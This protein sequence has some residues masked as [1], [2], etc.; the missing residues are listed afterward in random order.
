MHPGK[1]EIPKYLLKVTDIFLTVH[2][3]LDPNKANTLSLPNVFMSSM[4]FILCSWHLFG[5]EIPR[6]TWGDAALWGAVSVCFCSLCSLEVSSWTLGIRLDLIGCRLLQKKNTAFEQ[7]FL[8]SEVAFIIQDTRDSLCV[9]L[10]Q[11]TQCLGLHRYIII[12][13]VLMSTLFDWIFQTATIYW[14]RI[15]ERHL[16]LITAATNNFLGNHACK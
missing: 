3:N 1:A 6:W 5:K 14:E 9:V 2:L 10:S 15:Y 16:R 8:P 4:N 13:K 7:D 12:L 11:S